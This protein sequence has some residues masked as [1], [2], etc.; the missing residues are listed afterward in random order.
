M[1]SDRGHCSRWQAAGDDKMYIICYYSC[2]VEDIVEHHSA[3]LKELSEQLATWWR[4]QTDFKTKKA[5][6]GFLKVHPDTLGDYFS[7]RNF[8]R[9]DI[10]D[11]LCE[12][13]NIR[14]LKR[15][16]DSD[17]SSEMLPHPPGVT[18]SIGEP[19]ESDI[20]WPSDRLKEELH[21]EKSPEVIAR[22][23]PTELPQKEGRRY[24]E[25]SVVI[26]LQ[27]TSC[28]FCGHDIARFRRC[29]Y[30]GQ[31]FVWANVPLESGEPM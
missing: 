21:L 26:S 18:A 17:S 27:R 23:L 10:A 12:L 11:R 28:P 16:F 15:D 20:T 25:R 1:K 14:C 4:T 19:Q 2:K 13:T 5:L 22:Q 8:P 3:K 6:A 30:C 9:S 29:V 24:G 31:D 7:G